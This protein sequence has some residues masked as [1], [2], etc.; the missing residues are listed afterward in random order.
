MTPSPSATTIGP[1]FSGDRFLFVTFQ[2]NNRHTS[3]CALYVALSIVC[4]KTRTKFFLDYFYVLSCVLSSHNKR[5]L[6]C[7]VFVLPLRQPI[8]PFSTNK[9]LPGPPL[10]RDRGTGPFFFVPHPVRGG[11]LGWSSPAL[12]FTTRE[13]AS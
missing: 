1:Q 2:N 9:A 6:Y 8:P 7:I 5:I 3:S 11:V 12:H 13:A 10:H 4:I